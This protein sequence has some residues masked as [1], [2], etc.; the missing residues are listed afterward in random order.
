MEA[1]LQESHMQLSQRL[2]GAV[3]R[4]CADVFLIRWMV[5]SVAGW[6]GW[7][8]PFIHTCMHPCIHMRAQLALCEVRG[9]EKHDLLKALL[10]EASTPFLVCLCVY[11]HPDIGMHTP[12]LSIYIHAMPM[13]YTHV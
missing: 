11:I 5:D 1:A 10:K 3:Q 2:S 12:S 6:D 9:V 7:T 13:F 8:D 4:V